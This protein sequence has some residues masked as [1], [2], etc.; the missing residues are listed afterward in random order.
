MLKRRY[1]EEKISEDDITIYS[2][3]AREILLE[4]DELTPSEDAFMAGYE[5]AV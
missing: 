2:S 1:V 5:D 4:N 3:D